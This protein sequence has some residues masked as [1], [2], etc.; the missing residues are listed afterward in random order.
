MELMLLLIG[1]F[2]ADF[3][4]QTDRMAELKKE[5]RLWLFLHCAIYALLLAG[6]TLL[7][8]PWSTAW[9]PIVLLS[10]SHG[11]I[12]VL[13]VH[14]EKKFANN[15]RDGLIIFLA[16]Q[17]VHILI[18]WSIYYFL[19]GS[20]GAQM[21]LYRL[22]CSFSQQQIDHAIVY[23]LLFTL[24][25]QPAAVA[26]ATV[27][28]AIGK[29][30]AICDDKQGIKRRTSIRTGFTIGLFER[31]IIAILV[32]NQEFSTMAFVLTAKSLARHKQLEEP[33]FAEKYLVGTLLSVTIA[34]AAAV[35]LGKQL[36]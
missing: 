7:I 2:V 32:L 8:L 18:I 34:I 24:V 35:V 10:F 36:Q 15:A 31:I 16:D 11:V 17:G 19:I 23:V 3:V 20:V 22:L 14:A 1:H 27:L 28:S 9:L 13:R 4:V 21:P 5:R 12:D 26:V 29:A 25:L 6:I 33:A 30:P